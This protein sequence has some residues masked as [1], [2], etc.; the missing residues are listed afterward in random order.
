MNQTTNSDATAATTAALVAK[1]FAN[2]RKTGLVNKTTKNSSKKR[3][4]NQLG[5]RQGGVFSEVEH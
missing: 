2:G 5:S 1:Q 3:Q 4:T